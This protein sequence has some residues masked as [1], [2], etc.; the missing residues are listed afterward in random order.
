MRA[1]RTYNRMVACFGIPETGKSQKAIEFILNE[2]ATEQVYVFAHDPGYNI[3]KVL[4]DGRPTNVIR[5][6]SVAEAKESIKTKAGGIHA[7]A[8]EDAS[9]VITLAKEVAYASLV[10][11]T[12]GGPAAIKEGEGR[13]VPVIVFL[14]EIVNA[15]EA[16]PYRLG[17]QLKQLVTARRHE[18]IGIIYTAQSPK[19]CHYALST[20]VTDVYCFRLLDEK[21]VEHLVKRIHVPQD[22]AESAFNLSIDN[23]E[24]FHYQPGKGKLSA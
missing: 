18:H 5:H 24:Y 6:D 2:Q 15:Q 8:C 10:A 22:L 17:N 12:P 21:D 4:H 9:E 11:N 23:H 13:G 1:Q 19:L 14:D 7:I 20:M 3:P 16:S